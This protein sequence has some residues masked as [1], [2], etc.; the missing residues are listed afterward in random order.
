LF[1]FGGTYGGGG[2]INPASCGNNDLSWETSISFD[3]G[4]DV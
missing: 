3:L 4:L 1:G 2:A